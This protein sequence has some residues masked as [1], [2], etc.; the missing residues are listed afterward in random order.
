M[1]HSPDYPNLIALEALMQLMLQACRRGEWDALSNMDLQRKAMLEKDFHDNANG[2]H[3]SYTNDTAYSQLANKIL[4]LD[5][6]ILASVLEAR[7]DLAQEN[8][9]MREQV[10]AKS[11]YQQTSTM[12]HTAKR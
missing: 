4:Q 8:R 10:K 7:D 12:A 11:I 2:S 1:S 5:K 6:E 3:E 9:V